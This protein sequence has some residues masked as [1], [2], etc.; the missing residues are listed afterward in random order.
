MTDKNFDMACQLADDLYFK[1]M[2]N[3]SDDIVS[4]FVIDDKDNIG[5]TKNTDKGSDLYWQIE[6]TIKQ[7][8]DKLEEDK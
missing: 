4:E 7:A 6:D 3:L 2:D 1:F 8:L 5:G